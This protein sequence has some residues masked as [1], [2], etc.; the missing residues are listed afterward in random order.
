MR[1]AVA[2]AAAVRHMATNGKRLSPT[3]VLL[4]VAALAAMDIPTRR[5]AVRMCDA[6]GAPAPECR[7]YLCRTFGGF[8]KRE[9]VL[10]VL[11][12]VGELS[13]EDATSAAT[14]ADGAG[15][16]LVGTWPKPIAE[17]TY[18]GLIQ[19]GLKA[20]IEQ[21]AAVDQP[22]DDDEEDEVEEY[23]REVL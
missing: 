15:R 20:K 5:H 3:H 19:A 4:S 6:D 9:Y 16:A 8:G 7:V 22:S 11:M 2:T 12:M 1:P 23:C 13:E 10:R 17:H 21:A 14:Q 18:T